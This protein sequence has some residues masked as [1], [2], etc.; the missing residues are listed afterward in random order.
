MNREII[1]NK[2][3]RRCIVCGKSFER[4][5]LIRFSYKD[6]RI[7]LTGDKKADGRGVY[8]C[9]KKECLENLKKKD[10]FSRALRT[11]ISK[12]NLNEVEAKLKELSGR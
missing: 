12:Y 4:Q 6:G 2:P 5:N 7:F 10:Y 11:K 9:N 8:I 3:Y 1:K